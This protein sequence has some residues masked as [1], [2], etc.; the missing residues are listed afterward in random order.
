MNECLYM[1]RPKGRSSGAILAAAF[2]FIGSAAF[3]AVGLNNRLRRLFIM[4]A[5]L[6]LVVF[7]LIVK[8]F[9]ATGYSYAVYADRGTGRVDLVIFEHTLAEKEPKTVCRVSL[10]AITGVEVFDSGKDSRR[11][12]RAALKATEGMSFGNYCVSIL[13]RSYCL[14]CYNEGGECGALKLAVD[15]GLVEILKR[16]LI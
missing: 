4:T 8:R 9:L 10:A 3:S 1:C 12:G 14:V 15:K 11:R 7:F 16:N 13:P 5:L 2:F 6:M